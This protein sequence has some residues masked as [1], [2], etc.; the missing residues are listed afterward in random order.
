MGGR[1]LPDAGSILYPVSL[2]SVD[3]NEDFVAA[4]G[5]VAE[6]A[7]CPL[8]VCPPLENRQDRW[9]QVGAG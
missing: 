7:K 2:P 5:A 4:V 9:I 8:T 6:K 3:N 1:I